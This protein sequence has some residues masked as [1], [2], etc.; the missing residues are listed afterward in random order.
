MGKWPRH[1]TRYAISII[2]TT[3]R[4]GGKRK[5]PGRG[6][7]VNRGSTHL[8]SDLVGTSPGH[9]SPIG[10]DLVQTD[11]AYAVTPCP[12]APAEQR[13]FRVEQLPLNPGRTLAL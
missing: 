13:P 2:S 3:G 10:L 11:G 6:G 9:G 4:T 8:G 5:A 1:E 12:E 7:W